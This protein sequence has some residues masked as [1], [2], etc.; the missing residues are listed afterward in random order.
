MP[1]SYQLLIQGAV[2]GQG[3]RP[4]LA[5]FA[6]A[7]NLAGR[8]CNTSQ[9]V[10]LTLHGVRI[11]AV[12][13]E[14]Q[15]RTAHPALAEAA[16]HIDEHAA[17]AETGFRIEDST[18]D[19]TNSVP[20]PRDV[21]IC[22][23][24]L[25]EFHSTSDRRFQYG[26]I[27]CTRCGPRYSII[28]E[29][30]YDRPRTTL[31]EFPFCA[32]CRKDYESPDRRRRHA[33]S[34]GCSS[35]GPRIWVT[36]RLGHQ[37]AADDTACQIA[38]LALR[39]G[40]IVALRGVGGYQ[41]LVDATNEAAV[42]RLRQRKRRLTKPFAILCRT[43]VISE[44]LGV[45]DD[46]A[47]QS[48]VDPSNPI[49]IAPRR[50]SRSLAPGIHPGLNDIGIMLP[51]TA[52]H[53]R[54]LELADRPL[55]C[56]S[57]NLEGSPLVVDVREA[58]SE[59]SGIADLQVHHDRPIRHSL[60]DSVVRS[61]AGRSVTI[62]CG[63]GMAPLPLN[64][65]ISEPTVALG[66]FQK[67]AIACGNGFQAV[68]G[69]Y[70]GDLTDLSTRDRWQHSLRDLLELYQA[71]PAVYAADGHPDDITRRLLPK[72]LPIVDVW[73]HHAHIVAGMLE[74]NW[75]DEAVIGIAADGQGFGPDGHLWGC[76]VMEATATG[77]QRLATLRQYALPG[78]EAAVLDPGRVAVSLLSQLSRVSTQEIAE[79]TGLNS[80]RLEALTAS[81]GIRTT[82]WT[83]SLGRLF[84]A[85]AWLIVGDQ[86]P[87]YVGEPAALLEAACD[88][89]TTG[90]YEWELRT[91]RQ[92]WQ[93]D[94]RP[95]LV[96]LLRDRRRE[97][98]P[99][100]MAERF[101]RGVANVM[102]N[103]YHHCPPRPLVLGGGVFQN[104]RLCELLAMDW[105]A[106]GPR[107]GLPGNIPPNDSGLAAGQLAIVS[108]LRRQYGSSTVSGRKENTCA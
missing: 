27:S 63:R 57:G 89:A 32:A 50:W 58:L 64:L 66:A 46:M 34:I 53:D 29:M 20:V 28:Q 101:H 90:C 23:E 25:S 59:L 54:L 48:L 69:P 44:Q 18:T 40:Q 85:V 2:Q 68:L 80:R 102:R 97:V 70:V 74:Q 8:V 56:T 93:L 61:M 76:E 98:L 33:Q 100:V 49:V 6:E 67:A 62:R 42:A 16:I 12:Q 82:P 87:G 17:S 78:G 35:C 86:P 52:V 73:H 72:G 14:R 38:A 84:D 3:I 104:R 92:P 83:S 22:P 11:P 39:E 13:L 79:I 37:L 60:D 94:W 77:F 1:A 24:C 21:A 105:P 55:V 96:E 36:D 88:P 99:G 106:N 43:V 81:M 75:L 30:P 91:D 31:A 9:G 103:V 107:L 15:I 47:R 26:L 7:R 71:E 51:T 65:T 108:A 4:A 10:L 95:M 41:L 45:L 19:A 5:R